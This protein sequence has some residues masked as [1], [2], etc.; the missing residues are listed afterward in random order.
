M[1]KNTKEN[2]LNNYTYCLLNNLSQ[3]YTGAIF[4]L[5]PPTLWQYQSRLHLPYDIK[6][7]LNVLLH[8]NC[9]IQSYKSKDQN[10]KSCIVL[11]TDIPPTFDLICSFFFF[12]HYITLGKLILN[13]FTFVWTDFTLKRFIWSCLS[14]SQY[15]HTNNNKNISGL[16]EYSLKRPKII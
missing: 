13:L 2:R 4:Q 7:T 9:K 5:L 10:K 1:T 14:K 16:S 12:I 3:K 15:W 11:I 6:P 8:N